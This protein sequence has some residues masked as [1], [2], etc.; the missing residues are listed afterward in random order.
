MTANGRRVTRMSLTFLT[1]LAAGLARGAT[2]PAQTCTSTGAATRTCELTAS[3]GTLPLPGGTSVPAW[4]Y[5]LA[6]GAPSVPGP[7]LIVNQGETV[8]VT[9]VNQLP[10]PTA[11]L[12]HGQAMAPDL[13]GATADGGIAS[14]T[15]VADSPGTF[16]YEAGLLPNSAPQVAM[17]LYGVLIVRPATAGQAYP[18]ASSA[19]DD[20]ALVVLSE[21]DPALNTRADPATFDMRDFA[22]KYFLI[23][24]K[25]Y[26]ET[27]LI[28]TGAGRRVLLRYANAG[29]INH[30][31]AL[32][33]TDQRLLAVDGNPKGFES[34]AVAESI[35][36]G[37]TLDA[38]ALVPALAPVG[39]RFALYDA[40]FTLHNDG[41]AGFGGMLTFL[42][43]GP[44]SGGG[45]FGPATTAVLASPNPTD[46]TLAVTL[47]ALCDNPGGACCCA[48]PM[49][50]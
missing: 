46:G 8:T 20:E 17:G 33:G 38:I 47:S 30:S 42:S 35:G 39:S 34:R 50:A 1:L 2:L 26:P 5:S 45:D 3:V 43:T 41:A 37:Q 10:V 6:G 14:S 21:V 40:S 29:Q 11:L 4:T 9:L 24:G 36:T 27:E 23:N 22:P 18:T 25:A 48:T 31:M 15:F 32:L 12:F 7:V 49:R 16:L 19:F 44:L 13:V 28:A